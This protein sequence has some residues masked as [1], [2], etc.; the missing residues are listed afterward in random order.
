M[1]RTSVRVIWEKLIFYFFWMEKY[2]F[3]IFDFYSDLWYKMRNT[4][5]AEVLELL[6]EDKNQ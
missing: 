3:E 5:F 2:F 4:S 6:K 1:H